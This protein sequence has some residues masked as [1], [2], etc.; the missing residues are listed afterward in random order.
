MYQGQWVAIPG[1]VQLYKDLFGSDDTT[2]G[3]VISH[4]RISFSHFTALTFIFSTPIKEENTIISQ[5]ITP[6]GD[7]VNDVWKIKGIT[8]HAQSEI[9]IYNQHAVLIFFHKGYY[10][11]DWEGIHYISGQGVP[12]GAYYYTID[13]HGIGK[14]EKTGWIYIKYE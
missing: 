3:S 6:N 1:A 2:A 4:E 7:G 11:N 5:V 9:K 10:A 14:A 8:F 12:E 13:I